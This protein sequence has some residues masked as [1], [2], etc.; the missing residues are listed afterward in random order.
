MVEPGISKGCSVDKQLGRRA[1]YMIDRAH[2][3]GDERRLSDERSLTWVL[4]QRPHQRFMEQP[5]PDG[6]SV[7]T[8][9]SL[10]LKAFM[11]S[12]GVIKAV[13]EMP[14]DGPQKEDRSW[15]PRYELDQPSHPRYKKLRLAYEERKAMEEAFEMHSPRASREMLGSTT[16]NPGA[17]DDGIQTLPVEMP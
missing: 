16:T 7:A 9:R 10:I 2:I 12:E 5:V 1:A 11:K 14:Y 8:T 15:H 4:E 17:S 3:K 6:V 13:R